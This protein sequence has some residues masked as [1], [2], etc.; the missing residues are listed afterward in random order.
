MQAPT[1][2]RQ[3]MFAHVEQ[4]KIS[5]LSQKAY[6]AN[7]GLAYHVFHYWYKCYRSHYEP[8]E[9]KHRFMQVQ[10]AP[11]TTQA[12]VEVML[13]DGRRLLFHQPVSVDYLKA[14]LS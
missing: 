10:V 12:Y 8:G 2:T 13:T 14:L 7:C 4:W 9:A 5:G 11:S 3:R 6:C 1:E